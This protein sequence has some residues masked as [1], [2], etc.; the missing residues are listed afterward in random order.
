MA[1][2]FG[3]TPVTGYRTYQ[4]YQPRQR[5]YN[6]N[7]SLANRNYQVAS[8]PVV[9]EAAPRKMSLLKKAVLLLGAALAVKFVVGKLGLFKKSSSEA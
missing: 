9:E 6:W 8:Q 4:G 3:T 5:A 1:M 7:H 2:T